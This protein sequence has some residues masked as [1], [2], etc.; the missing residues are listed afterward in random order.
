[1][2]PASMPSRVIIN[3]DLNAGLTSYIAGNLGFRLGAILV[4]DHIEITG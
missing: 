1:M 2:A 3:P 4:A